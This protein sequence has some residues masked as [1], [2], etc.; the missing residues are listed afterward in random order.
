MHITYLQAKGELCPNLRWMEISFEAAH[1]Y[2]Y[3]Y[4]YYYHYYY[5]YYYYCYII[6]IVLVE[7]VSGLYA[8]RDGWIFRCSKH[9][10]FQ[11]HH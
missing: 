4:Y 8:L 7:R 1:V 6:H 10:G 3:Y 5:Y 11:R 2:Y 9:P